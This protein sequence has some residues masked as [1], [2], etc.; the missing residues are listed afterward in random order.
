MTVRLLI[1]EDEQLA[2]D[3]LLR[4]LVRRQDVEVVGT[5]RSGAEGLAAIA[6][7][8]P[9][10][11]LLDVEMPGLDGFDLVE[12][13]SRRVSK[14]KAPLI[15]F[16]TAYPQ[17]AAAAFDTGAIDF[18]TKPVRFGRLEIALDRLAHEL[19]TR[20][21]GERLAQLTQQL[22][23]LRRERTD[24]AAEED[25]LWVQRRGE[26]VS[27]ALGALDRVS[28]E[29]EYIRLHRGDTQFL[30]RS[31]ITSLMPRLD[32]KRFVRIHRSHVVNVSHIASIL[33]RPAGG[34]RIVTSDG[35]TLPV[36][37]TYHG[38][39]RGLIMIG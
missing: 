31:S 16:V 34:Y 23:Q 38:A 17:F 32:P 3:R 11:V 25:R 12:E 10:A 15:I 1:C 22:D 29:G 24:G 28:A 14:D 20:T 27:V 4:L 36:G 5:A 26:L 18:L 35:A 33:R 39:V 2:T 8:A 13:L 9:D 6:E 37:R 7:L 19:A 30:H 21:A